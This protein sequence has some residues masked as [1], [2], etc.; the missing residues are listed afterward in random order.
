MMLAEAE[1]ID[2]NLHEFGVTYTHKQAQICIKRNQPS[3]LSERICV[4]VRIG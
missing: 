4:V 2:L 3:Q 1:C